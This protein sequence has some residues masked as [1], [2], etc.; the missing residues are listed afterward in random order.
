MLNIKYFKQILMIQLS[1]SNLN[2]RNSNISIIQTNL[3][4]REISL[5]NSHNFLFVIRISVTQKNS[6][7]QTDF[8]VPLGRFSM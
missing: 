3:S 8:Q 2:L 5:R 7:I 4:H 6:I 1:L